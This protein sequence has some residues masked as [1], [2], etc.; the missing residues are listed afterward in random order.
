MDRFRVSVDDAAL[1]A[2]SARGDREAF[3]LFYRRHLPAVVAFLVRETGDRELAGDLAGE[4]FC[5]ALLGC[6]RYRAEYES[7]LPWL[8]GIARFK[9]AESRRRGRVEDRARRRLGVP[10]ET[11]VDADLERV[12]ELAAK[13]SGVLALLDALPRAQA[14]AVRA[15]VIEERSYGEIAAASGSTEPAVRQNVSRAL[16]WLRHRIRTEDI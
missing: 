5:A 6:A 3:A 14:E 8:C 9:V 4:V 12:E 10:R 15:R 7:A 16:A 13:G 1:L 11:L 2:G